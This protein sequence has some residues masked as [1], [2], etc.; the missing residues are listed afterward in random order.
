M[1]QDSTQCATKKQTED[2]GR[3]IHVFLLGLVTHSS[4]KWQQEANQ[5]KENMGKLCGWIRLVDYAECCLTLC[6]KVTVEEW[7]VQEAK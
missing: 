2:G 3:Q 7:G 4:P 6:R 5:E 1:L